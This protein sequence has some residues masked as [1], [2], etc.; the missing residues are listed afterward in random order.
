MFHS[1]PLKM[2]QSLHFYV[3]RHLSPLQKSAAASAPRPC[4][5]ARCGPAWARHM[6]FARQII[7]RAKLCSRLSATMIFHLSRAPACAR[8]MFLIVD[9]IGIGLRRQAGHHFTLLNACAVKFPFASRQNSPLHSG[10][11]NRRKT[12][13]SLGDVYEVYFTS[14]VDSFVACVAKCVA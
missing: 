7:G 13:Y 11:V 1:S 3:H 12:F 9:L 6:L 2:R 14:N 5:Q 4:F 10:D 8:R